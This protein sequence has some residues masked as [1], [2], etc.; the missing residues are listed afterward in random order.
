MGVNQF[1]SNYL[2]REVARA[3]PLSREDHCHRQ[4]RRWLD[5]NTRVVEEVRDIR[6]ARQIEE[7][8]RRGRIA[9]VEA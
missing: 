6:L 5:A 2:L 8:S 9:E 4:H 3:Y 1:I 7:E